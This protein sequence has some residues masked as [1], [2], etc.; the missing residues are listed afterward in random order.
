MPVNSIGKSELYAVPWKT[1]DVTAGIVLAVA[2]VV[3]FT[4]IY[5]II[6]QAINADPGLDLGFAIVGGAAYGIV[7]LV[8]WVMGPIRYGATLGSLGLKLPVSRNYHQLVLPLLALAASLVFTGLYVVAV[9]VLGWDALEPG[10]QT[11]DIILEG[12]AV[13]G[14]FV[15][16]VLWGPLAEE[17][18]FRG[19]VFPGL[20]GQ[21]GLIG[22]AVASSFLF[23]LAHVDPGVMIPIFV[24][25]LILA[26]LYHRTGSLWSCF[27]AHALQNALVLSVGLWL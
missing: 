12:P 5:A 18:F 20:V 14:S 19:F 17:V 6:Y 2:G 7:L 22:A 10:P 23:A 9:S 24:T 1:S 8:S 4:I 21:L 26:W 11:D 13:I 27:V 16:A 3:V 15:L 25:G